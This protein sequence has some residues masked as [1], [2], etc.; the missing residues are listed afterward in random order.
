MLI[1]VPILVLLTSYPAMSWLVTA[2]TFAK[3]LVVELWFSFF[4]GVYN[5]AMV[6]LLTEMMPA[7]VRTAAFSLAYSLATAVFGGFTPAIC[8]YLIARSGNTAA[9]AMW[10]MLAAAISFVGVIFSRQ[11]SIGGRSLNA[12]GLDGAAPARAT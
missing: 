9:P 5:G 2:P 12:L 10:L 7:H 1:V 8:T 11:L 3:L 4:F 6:P